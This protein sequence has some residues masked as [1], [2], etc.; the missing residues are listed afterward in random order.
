M[1]W[2][3][4]ETGYFELWNGPT[5]VLSA[6][7]TAEHTDGRQI[8]TRTAQLSGTHTEADSTELVFSRERA[9]S[10]REAGSHIGR[11]SV[12]LLFPLRSKRKIRGIPASFAAYY[13]GSR[14]GNIPSMEK[15]LVTNASGSV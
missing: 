9:G 15:P 12:C 7:S 4:T 10:H 2:K 1:E 8:D 14:S 13:A 11:Y 5:P 3:I 6:Y